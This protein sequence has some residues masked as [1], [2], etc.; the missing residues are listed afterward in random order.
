MYIFFLFLILV[1][2]FFSFICD[3][4]LGSAIEN[5]EVAGVRHNPALSNSYQ[6]ELAGWFKPLPDFTSQFIP[7]TP[8]FIPQ[9]FPSIDLEEGQTKY[10]I[11]QR[12]THD[13]ID[14]MFTI[15]V[16]KLIL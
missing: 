16:S 12:V 9:A 14:K 10:L 6:R 8:I 11:T 4:V 7:Y 1:I 2:I 3:F 15:R 13:A 5:N